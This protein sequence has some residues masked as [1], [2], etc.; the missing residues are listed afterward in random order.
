MY[1]Q[2]HSRLATEQE[3]FA[4]S[5]PP[6]P[7]RSLTPP[8]FSPMASNGF[9]AASKSTFLSASIGKEAQNL[10]QDLRKLSLFLQS[11]GMPA[12][13]ATSIMDPYVLGKLIQRYQTEVLGWS[14]VDGRA[15]PGGKTISAILALQGK[16]TVARWGH[17]IFSKQVPRKAKPEKKQPC[18]SPKEGDSWLIPPLLSSD[19]YITQ[20][21]PSKAD[22]AP[23]LSNAQLFS[24]A[25]AH[26]GPGQK[27]DIRKPAKWPLHYKWKSKGPWDSYEQAL[28]QTHW[29]ACHNTCIAMAENAGLSGVSKNADWNKKL[30][31]SQLKGK[32]AAGQI[33]PQLQTGAVVVVRVNN[34]HSILIVGKG[35]D[36]RGRF[37]AF[38]DPGRTGSKG[39]NLD[40]NR[41]YISN[42]QLKGGDPKYK[43]Y[44][45]TE[46]RQ[47][48][49]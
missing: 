28:E 39:Y 16:E 2:S 40:K 1:A 26:Y 14:R 15:D 3:T 41:L 37:Y 48:N 42:G 32:T 18:F 8:Q 30:N 49:S 20:A 4:S 13:L 43:T 11:N 7:G 22:G 23:T 46:V 19:Q 33:D 9:P 31:Q 29:I 44:S 35:E 25:L 21:P 47:S 10:P 34:Y 5:E 36:S 45:V 6:M 38:F 27:R 17:E 12:L 24:H